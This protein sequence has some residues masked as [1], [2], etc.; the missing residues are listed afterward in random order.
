MH[1]GI[2]TMHSVPRWHMQWCYRVSFNSSPPSATYMRQW[3]RSVLV[4]IVTFH[5]FGAKP[6]SEGKLGCGHLGTNFSEFSIKIQNVSFPKMHLKNIV[7]EMAAI[8]SRGRWQDIK[9][10]RGCNTNSH[11]NRNVIYLS[12]S[13]SVVLSEMGEQ[14]INQLKMSLDLISNKFSEAV[15]WIQISWWH[16]FVWTSLL[17]HI[18]PS[19]II[20]HIIK[21]AYI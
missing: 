21:S 3:S 18:W 17:G 15:P 5:L 12:T 2:Q 14:L 8:L 20:S 16:M 9:V 4:Q 7:C 10:V 6:L 19:N 13:W 11:R 1:R